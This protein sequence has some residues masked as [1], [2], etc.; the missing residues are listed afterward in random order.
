[1][2]SFRQKVHSNDLSRN[3][4]TGPSQSSMMHFFA[5]FLS[6][7]IHFGFIHWLGSPRPEGQWGD[8]VFVDCVEHLFHD[9]IVGD[10]GS[11]IQMGEQTRRYSY[12]MNECHKNTMIWVRSA[13]DSSIRKR[14]F[15]S[16][17]VANGDVI[18]ILM[19]T[20]RTMPQNVI[21]RL[22]DNIAPDDDIHRPI[23]RHKNN[24]L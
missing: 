2:W 20:A 6:Y 11:V 16:N 15:T 13:V 4:G 7:S 1:M 12:H 21:E 9:N 22:Q 17:D 18:Y 19:K 24:G 23:R 3:L 14:R 8:S 5:C 10:F